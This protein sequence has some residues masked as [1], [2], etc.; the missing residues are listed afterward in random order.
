MVNVKTLDRRRKSVRNIRKITRTMELIASAQ[1]KRAMDRAAAATAYTNRITALVGE[2]ASAGLEVSHPLLETREKEA[3]AALLIIT[4]NRG[5]CGGYN[6]SV[7]R[8]ALAELRGLREKVGREGAHLEV[9][10]K[11]GVGALKFRK[12]AMKGEYVHFGDKPKFDEVN[13]LA[14]R[15]LEDFQTGKLDRVEI[16][17]TKFFSASRQAPVVETLLPMT[18]L[19]A[20]AESGKSAEKRESQYEFL[21]T[22]SDILSEVV[23]TAFRVKLFK[24]FLDAAVSEQIAR[25]A[26]MKSATDNANK[27]IGE[28]SR[29]YNRAR[30]TKITGELLEVVG[31]ADAVS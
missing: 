24:C 31:G 17:Y 27:M 15:L 6:S 23:P 2:L 18:G 19:A 28:L 21:P 16:V 5:L 20:G 30:Q 12:F 3:N 7:I 8:S 13:A 29:K 22:P 1:F 10:G 26:A 9:V 14:T 11:R 25:R 4:S